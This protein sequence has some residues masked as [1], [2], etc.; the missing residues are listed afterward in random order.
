MD[1]VQAMKSFPR[2]VCAGNIWKSQATIGTSQVLAK[3][4]VRASSSEAEAPK[5]QR[6]HYK[7]AEDLVQ[8]GFSRPKIMTTVQQQVMAFWDSGL[9]AEAIWYDSRSSGSVYVLFLGG[10]VAYGCFLSVRI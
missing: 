5:T 1:I 8:A 6:P 10:G 7:L 9:R 3:V 4:L 2:G